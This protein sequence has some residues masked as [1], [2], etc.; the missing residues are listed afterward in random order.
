MMSSDRN[1]LIRALADKGM[2]SRAI[3]PV[4]GLT[5]RRGRQIIAARWETVSHLHGLE[6]TA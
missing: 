6:A 1:Q 5:D 2:S 4:V 3:A